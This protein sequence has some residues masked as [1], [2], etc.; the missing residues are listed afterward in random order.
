MNTVI[1]LFAALLGSFG[2][3]M[4][5]NS[6]IKYALI[7]SLGGVCAW[8]IYLIADMF[9]N[10]VFFVCLCASFF[11][12]LFGEICAKL[13]KAPAPVFFITAVIPLIPGSML[14]HTI[15]SIVI[16]DWSAASKFAF[17]TAE[18][19][20]AIAIGGSF[21]WGSRRIIRRIIR[22]HSKSV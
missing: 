17:L 1:Q 20:F 2:F 6:K 9:F 4:L 22:K 18:Y 13:F 10:R 19:A 14:Y 16:S 21:V 15:S 7:G 12:A 8:G 3:A 5:F 11:A